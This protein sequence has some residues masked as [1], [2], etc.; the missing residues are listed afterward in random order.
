MAISELSSV[1]NIAVSLAKKKKFWGCGTML[2]LSP[3][4]GNWCGVVS[5]DDNISVDH[6]CH[7]QVPRATSGLGV[8]RQV[9]RENAIVSYS[10]SE[11]R[12]T[13]D[14][15]ILLVGPQGYDTHLVIS[16]SAL[17]FRFDY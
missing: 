4:Q 8:R 13:G 17:L 10:I 12:H 1:I 11:T 16:D 7:H 15:V 5:C 14:K 2:V 9:K 6:H 3:F